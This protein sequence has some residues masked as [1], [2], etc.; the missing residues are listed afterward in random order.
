MALH[1]CTGA[2]M[3]CSFGVAPATFSAT[4]KMIMT[5]NM[6]AGNIMDHVPFLNIPP[7]GMCS[8]P[9]NPAVAAATA[10][11]MG[12]LTPMP[13]TPVTPAPWAPGAPTV[14][15][16]NLPAL[17]NSSTLMCAYAGVINFSMAGQFTELVP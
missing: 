1:C 14:L 7:F 8:S 16:A 15:V 3:T 9:A 17:N 6:P 11:A 13:C 12:V 4:P 10:A 5:G 2:L